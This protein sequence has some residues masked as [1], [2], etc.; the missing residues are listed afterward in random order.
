VAL[1]GGGDVLVALVDHLDRPTGALGEDRAVG[2]QHRRVLLL[3]AEPAAGDGLRDDDVVGAAAEH[4][5]QRLVHVVRALHRAGDVE[6]AVLPGRHRLGL[7]VHLLLGAGV[8]GAV[9]D[10]GRAGHRGVEL[11][12]VAVAL[13]DQELLEDVVV[14]V[15]LDLGG[16]GVVDR[17]HRRQRALAWTGGPT[18]RR[19]QRLGRGRDQ[20]DRLVGVGD[21]PARRHQGRLIAVDHRDVVVA[22]ATGGQAGS[23]RE[24]IGGHDHH[25]RP[26][27]GRI[28][29]EPLEDPVGDR[30][31][32]RDAV[33]GARHVEIVEVA[34]GAGD[35]GD[36]IDA[37]DRLTDRAGGNCHRRRVARLPRRRQARDRRR[38]RP[39]SYARSAVQGWR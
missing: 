9:D 29:V 24:L 15:Q 14:A 17:E 32:D 10:L 6:R 27:E 3:A 37:R 30:R 23:P 22:Q 18:R 11:V 1:G 36:A 31:A 21:A 19:R 7:D 2:R 26:I 39:W 16:E 28:E 12:V 35:L 25:G 13:A 33:P 5:L 20:R 4:D 8:I 34:R 38:V